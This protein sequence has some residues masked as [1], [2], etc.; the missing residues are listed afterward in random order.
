MSNNTMY[1][2]LIYVPMKTKGEHWYL[3]VIALKDKKI[4]HLDSFCNLEEVDKR[5]DRILSVVCLFK[6]A[7][8]SNSKRTSVFWQCK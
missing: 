5:Q 3:M 4:Y 6:I 8:T 2:S 7:L 1:A